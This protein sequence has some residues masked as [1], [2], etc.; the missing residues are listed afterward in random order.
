MINSQK[1]TPPHTL[2]PSQKCLIRDRISCY[3][4]IEKKIHRI[5]LSGIVCIGL[6]F[7][8]Y[9]L[10]SA[11]IISGVGTCYFVSSHESFLHGYVV[12][13]VIECAINCKWG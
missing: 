12:P 7:S 5:L 2:R 6:F 13:V 1:I 8:V 11:S 10:F 3:S 9:I 4:R